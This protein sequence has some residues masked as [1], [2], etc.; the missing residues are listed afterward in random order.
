MKLA[1]LRAFV[2]L[3]EERHFG[4]AAERLAMAQPPFSQQIK[5]LEEELEVTLVSRARRP[6]ELT[7]AG[8][9]FLHEARR[10]L[11][12][13]EAARATARRVGA[14]YEGRLAIGVVGSAAVEF[15]PD[16]LRRFR[17]RWPAVTL[18]VREMPSPLQLEA[19]VNGG[20][21]LGFVRPPV[22]D[23]T[24][25]VRVIAQEPFVI[26]LPI[27]HAAA[28][29]PALRLADLSGTP[30]VIFGEEE[31]PGFHGQIMHLCQRAGYA[32]SLVQEASQMTTMI[33]LV[34]AGLGAAVVPRAARRLAIEGVCYRPIIDESPLADLC[35]VW[36]RDHANRGIAEMITLIDELSTS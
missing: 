24:L 8:R 25:T 33:A 18:S 26:A 10:I 32:P 34:A 5:T 6:I 35:A 1:H 4:R 2:M 17:E 28:H 29:R 12:Q 15:L 16:I 3:A 22:V 21:D 11:H 31:A 7:S 30:L 20:L 36:R 23:P 13:V 14:G 19:L 27:E 9:A